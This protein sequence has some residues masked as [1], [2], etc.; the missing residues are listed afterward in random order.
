[1]SQSPGVWVAAILTI[2]MYTYLYKDNPAFKFGE[3]L[4]VGIGAAHAV[5]MG[6]GNIKE[7]A[8]KPFVAGKAIMILPLLMGLF[9]FSRYVFSGKS[10]NLSRIPIAFLSGLAAALSIR[11]LLDASLIRQVASTMGP[12]KTLDNLLLAVGVVT[13]VTYFLFTSGSRKGPIKA[14]A[15]I[16][17]CVMMITF[18]AAFGNTVMARM[19]LVI[20]RLQFLFGQWIKIM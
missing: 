12:I 6:Y 1:M 15:D 14:S 5:V 10:A 16:G 9:L 13:T 18:G 19:S 2:C 8:W 7:M 4:F 20:G 11:G 3:H 17:R